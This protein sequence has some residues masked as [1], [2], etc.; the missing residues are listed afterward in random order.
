MAWNEPGGNNKDPWGNRGNQG[1]PDLDEVVRKMQNKL[2]GLFGGGKGG[3]SGSKSSMPSFA[4][5][6]LLLLIGAVI[7]LFSG[8]Y[9]VDAGKQE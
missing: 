3:G 7:W 2:G 1:P 5:L 8:I 6:G 4:G 9:I